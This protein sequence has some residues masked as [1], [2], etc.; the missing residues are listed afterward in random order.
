MPAPPFNPED[1]FFIWATNSINSLNDL[2]HAVVT[3][4]SRRLFRANY[5]ERTQ[6]DNYY[7]RNILADQQAGARRNWQE[8]T[9]E[10]FDIVMRGNLGTYEENFGNLRPFLIGNHIGGPPP[11]P[12]TLHKIGVP[13][14]KLP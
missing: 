10:G 8:I 11:H 12:V 3:A 7:R 4:N 14:G 13:K 2:T 1:R 5:E 9:R 6:S